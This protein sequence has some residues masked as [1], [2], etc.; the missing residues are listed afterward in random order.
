[1]RERGNT[2]KFRSLMR[3]T[4]WLN[5]NCFPRSFVGPSYKRDIRL[6][7]QISKFTFLKS[8][9]VVLV[10]T[11]LHNFENFVLNTFNVEFFRIL[12]T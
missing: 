12:I 4:L 3:A 10:I 8:V 9:D 7:K 5:Q 6:S 2:S 11:T 1:M